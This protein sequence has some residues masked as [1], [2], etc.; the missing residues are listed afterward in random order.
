MWCDDEDADK[1]SADNLDR[2]TF[3]RSSMDDGEELSAAASSI[4]S[5][6]C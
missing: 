5:N 6:E 2:L 1:F 3:D 4:A